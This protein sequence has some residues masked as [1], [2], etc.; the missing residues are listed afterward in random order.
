[1]ITA[2]DTHS[3]AA[4]Y[5]FVNNDYSLLDTSDLV[6]VD[7]PGTGFG[8]IVGENKEKS[9]Y[10]VDQDGH[11]FAEFIT[12]FLS[13]YQ[14]WNSPQISVRRELWHDPVGGSGQLAG[15]GPID[16]L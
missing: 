8:R 16:R 9:F 14:R 5:S 6:F 11:A 15:N 1:M 4:P 13:K 7:A 2:D 10:G 12:A 3:P